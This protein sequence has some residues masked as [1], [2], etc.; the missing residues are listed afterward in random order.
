VTDNTGIPPEQLKTWLAYLSFISEDFETAR[1]QRN[2]PNQ[3]AFDNA[4]FTI[5]LIAEAIEQFVIPGL[6]SQADKATQ[7][8]IF[9]NARQQL[10]KKD[11][12][13]WRKRRHNRVHMTYKNPERNHP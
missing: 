13:A 6:A 4:M 12:P 1:D 2:T 11:L 10:I 5:D 9:R 8:E 3:S 7:R